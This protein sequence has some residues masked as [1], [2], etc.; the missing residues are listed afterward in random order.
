[1]AW[2]AWYRVVDGSKYYYVIRSALTF[3]K[4]EL[5]VPTHS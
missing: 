4:G 5:L 1:M 2:I 3:S